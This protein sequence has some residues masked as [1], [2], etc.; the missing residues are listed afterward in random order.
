MPGP[1]SAAA[2]KAPPTFA[3][4]QTYR[5]APPAA[6][7]A[8]LPHTTQSPPPLP[9][10]PTTGRPPQ[11]VRYQKS[12]GGGGASLPH[13][14]SSGG[15][16]LS[17]PSNYAKSPPSHG[18]PPTPSHGAPP[19]SVKSPP[20]GRPQHTS[21]GAPPPPPPLVLET[22]YQKSQAGPP[23]SS[24][25]ASPHTSMSPRVKMPTTPRV[26]PPRAPSSRSPHASQQHTT[27]SLQSRPRHSPRRGH[28]QHH[29]SHHQPS[30][31]DSHHHHHHHRSA[32]ASPERGPRHLPD[33]HSSL[34]PHRISPRRPR[35]ATVVVSSPHQ[36]H[37]HHHHS[38]QQ[39]HH[40]HGGRSH[41]HGGSH[42]APRS[43]RTPRSQHQHHP[44]QH[45]YAAHHTSQPQGRVKTRSPPP[46]QH[47]HHQQQA[48]PPPLRDGH[49]DHRDRRDHDSM[50]RSASLYRSTEVHADDDA[51]L[52]RISPRRS[53]GGG[54]GGGRR[55]VI[56]PR[57]SGGGGSVGVGRAHPLPPAQSP[58]NRFPED[59]Y[60]YGAGDVEAYD[61]DD[62]IHPFARRDSVVRG[63]FVVEGCNY[64][65]FESA[66]QRCEAS[67]RA[68]TTALRDDI[69]ACVGRGVRR[70][71]IML[72]AAPGPVRGIVLEYDDER[73]A[74]SPQ[75]VDA[76]WGI[77]FEYAIRVR[78]DAVQKQVGGLL[79]EA[80][81]SEEGL[82]LQEARHAWVRYVDEGADPGA[83][84]TLTTQDA[85]R[86][87]TGGRSV[88]MTN[89]GTGSGGHLRLQ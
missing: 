27:S 61:E 16:S 77:E 28:S 56:S 79:Y 22:S 50:R 43:P 42:G 52:A 8:S 85:T 7:A 40:S 15:V 20:G 47:H 58:R 39:P 17:P 4:T 12:V 64:A 3:P 55:Y 89:V 81:T 23:P 2:T 88:A 68:F 45:P 24:A 57:G 34:P 60:G 86:R 83:I 19:P 13:S 6:G 44:Q 32:P 66:G 62:L 5:K 76:D 1:P 82:D 49:P 71:D 87:A 18:A 69:V 25:L 14:A 73:L 54:G 37:H 67:R 26:S 75:M 74:S 10:P 80:L 35:A 38:R 84:Y 31:T 11:S 46:P 78:S 41:S 9:L 21:F 53:S 36:E 65:R 30:T 29:S 59:R 70:H 63:Q 33:D 72:R 51:H 48:H